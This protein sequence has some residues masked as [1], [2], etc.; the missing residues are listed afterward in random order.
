MDFFELKMDVE[1]YRYLANFSRKE[2]EANSLHA[3]QAEHEA[4][5]PK[6]DIEET[7]HRA[8]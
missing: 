5:E 3:P 4:H 2:D 6:V 8:A 1:W 7:Q